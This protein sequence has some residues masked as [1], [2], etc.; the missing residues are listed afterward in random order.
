MEITDFDYELP[1]E[2]IAQQAVVPK[3]SSRLMVIES[4][5]IEHKHFY[6]LP[7]YLTKGD[8]LVINE[9]KVAASKISGQKTT[10][11]RVELILTKKT[12]PTRYECRIRG[13]RIRE[14]DKY[15]FSKDL[16]CKLTGRTNDIFIVEFNRPLGQKII[17]RLFELPIPPYIKKKVGNNSEYQTVYSKK[18]GSLAAPTA[19]LHFTTKLMKEIEAKGVKIARLCLHI[20]FGT[21]LSIKGKIEEHKMHEEYFEISKK[22]ADTINNRTGRLILVGTTSVRSLESAADSSGKIIPQKS[23]TSI[24]IYPGYR[25]KTQIDALI[26]N[27][28]LPKSTLLM[29]VSAYYGREKILAAYREAIAERY[30]FYSLGDAMLLI[31]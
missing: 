2:R 27:F 17:G 19:G 10:G 4:G 14:G 30:R 24:F 21:F 16:K 29:L 13:N 26:T 31:K 20:D 3:D 9:T 1:K 18:E 5:K 25:F 8:V 22:A 28:H 12:S 6:H 23:K 11:S 15:I 7:A